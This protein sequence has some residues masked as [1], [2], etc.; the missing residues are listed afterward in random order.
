[1]SGPGGVVWTAP[2]GLDL[3]A[4]LVVLHAGEAIPEHVNPS[5][6]VLLVVL[7]GT[8]VVQVDDQRVQ[9]RAHTA[10]LIPKG[11]SRS[12]AP[13]GGDGLRYMTVHVARPPMQIG[14][15]R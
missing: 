10:L 8:G 4:N 6:D 5:L 9:V 15:R 3:N 7:A 12:M 13:A 11:A 1:M 14:P 2:P